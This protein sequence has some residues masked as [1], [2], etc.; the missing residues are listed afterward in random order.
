MATILTSG[1]VNLYSTQKVLEGDRSRSPLAIELAT[2]AERCNSQLATSN[3]R[4]RA[5]SQMTRFKEA[6]GSVQ[7]Q[8]KLF[9]LVQNPVMQ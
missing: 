5:N 7:E 6:L 4:P 8:V 1:E 2:S 3:Y 9:F